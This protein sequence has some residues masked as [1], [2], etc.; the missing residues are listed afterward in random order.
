MTRPDDLDATARALLAAAQRR[1]APDPGAA[2]RNLDALARR[3]AAGEA[4]PLAGQPVSSDMPERTGP[5]DPDPGDTSTTDPIE[6]RSAL[7]AHRARTFVIALAVAAAVVAAVRLGQGLV[8]AV[9][10]TGG[11]DPGAAVDHASPTTAGGDALPRRPPPARPTSDATSDATPP[12]DPPTTA[13]LPEQPVRR[14][15]PPKEPAP[16]SSMERELSLVREAGAALRSSDGARAQ[17]L[18]DDYLREF[19]AGAFAPEARVLRAESICLQGQ[20]DAA[21]AEAARLF[22]ALAGSPL[23]ARAAAIC[24]AD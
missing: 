15:P 24:R 4:D 3:I 16:K 12:P 21:R 2:A 22:A 20:V 9:D 11:S 1:A 5:S 18:A 10:R 13:P 6:L 7:S 19:P 8:T 17:R 23:A 14:P